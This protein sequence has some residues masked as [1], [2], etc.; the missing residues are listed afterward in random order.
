VPQV[1]RPEIVNLG[2]LKRFWINNSVECGLAYLMDTPSPSFESKAFSVVHIGCATAK[3][4]FGHEMGHNKGC[5]HDRNKA[6]SAG[7]FPYSYGFQH[8]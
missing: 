2:L 6:G 8:S 4:S 5:Q 3:F 7:A 1:V